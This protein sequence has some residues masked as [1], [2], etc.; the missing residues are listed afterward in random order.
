MKHGCMSQDNL[1]S[2]KK[3]SEKHDEINELVF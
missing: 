2:Y 1:C 3:T